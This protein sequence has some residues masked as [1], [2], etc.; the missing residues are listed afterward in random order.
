MSVLL[1]LNVF[2]LF[3]LIIVKF[4]FEQFIIGEFHLCFRYD[5]KYNLVLTCRD[6]KTGA[7]REASLTKSVA[8]FIDENGVIIYELIEPEVCKLHNSISQDRKD[9]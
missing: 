8:S 1:I 9:K 3:V 2:M 7:V 5:D 6:G 4:T